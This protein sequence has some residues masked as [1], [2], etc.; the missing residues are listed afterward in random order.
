M[1]NL[2]S[3]A[4]LFIFDM[5]NNHMG[6]VEHGLNI[7][8][9]IQEATH[10]FAFNFGFKLQYRQLD[11]LIHPDFKD[12]MDFK[13]IK[14]F[15]ETRLAPSEMKELK[16]EMKKR[17]F[18]TVC[19]PFDEGSVDLIEEHDFDIIKVGSC[20]FT[21]WPLWERI[22]RT[23]KPIIAS[24]GG[25]SLEDIDKVVAFLEHR[26]KDFA[27]MHCVAEYPIPNSHLQLGQIELLRT[28]F[29]EA[30]IGYST[31]ED[32]DNVDAIKIAIGKG[33]SIFEKHAGVAT[34]KIKLNAYSVTPA[35]VR[36]WLEVA[37]QA[38]EICG[39]SDK[40]QEFD[41]AEIAELRSLGRGVFAGRHLQKGQRIQ[42][43]DVFFALPTQEGQLTA[44]DMSK[45]TEFYAEALLTKTHST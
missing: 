7:I 20:S 45:Y 9:K 4:P 21:D 2:K 35:Q 6:S 44:N 14:R 11:T 13:Y 42:L 41:P 40:R 22:A 38:F 19:T 33:A 26:Q 23:K 32:P 34:E 25:A 8:K 28:R 18:I 10:G 29:P 30:S 37:R 39:V 27:I 24:T 31:H 15:S 16:D 36:R 12:R 3:A 5:A 1:M 17:G 43:A